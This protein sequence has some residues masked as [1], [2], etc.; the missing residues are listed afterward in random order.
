[1]NDVS[2]FCIL[3]NEV[4]Y[5]VNLLNFEIENCRKYTGRVLKKA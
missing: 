3:L 1:M 4:I 2:S 5:N